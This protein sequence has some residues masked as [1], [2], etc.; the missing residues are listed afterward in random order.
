MRR[1][2]FAAASLLLASACAAAASADAERI[3]IQPSGQTGE[4][5]FAAADF[6]RVDLSGPFNVVVTVGGAHSVRAVGDTG[7]MEHLDIRSENGRLRVG[8]KEG[9]SYSYSGS[10]DRVTIHVITPA[11]SA[12]DVAGSGNM[13]VSAFR[14]ASFA[15][16]VAGSGN[17]TL[18]RLDTDRASFNVAGSGEL[19]GSGA[20]GEARV[21]V[22]GSGN[23]RLAALQAE[24]AHVS[25]A[26]SGNADLRATGEATISIAGSGNVAVTGGA[27]C[28]VSKVG[29][30]NARCS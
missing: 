28:L 15:G 19:R 2:L 17:L 14:A 26:G 11:L 13:Q 1:T 23:V 4:R 22:A 25:V 21:D 16:S 12:A 18:D 7:L 5:S 8:L 6:D 3:V 30:G 29:S 27:R 10:R 24:R 9:R 20:A